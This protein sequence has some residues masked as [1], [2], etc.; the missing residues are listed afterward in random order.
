MIAKPK[1]YDEININEEFEKLELGGHKGIIIK[2]EEYTSDF[3][4]KKSLKV[5]VDTASDDKQPE[6]FK[7]QYENDTRIDRK[8]PNGA[9]KYV[10]LG[11]E[12]NQVKMLKS[13]ITAYENSNGCKF[14]WNKDWV[15]LKGKKIGLVFGM[16]EYLNQE[17]KLKTVNKLR[18]FRSIDK[19]DNVKIPKVKKLDNSYVDYEEY[20]NSKNS[21][22]E[23]FSDFGNI[24]EVSAEDLPF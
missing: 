24:V 9:I 17:G 3:S 11:E 10:P 14:D 4:G 12:E 5:Y 16:E 8:Y 1:T 21:S 2:A 15:Q 22:N 18:E 20:I 6:Y 7:K 19:V 13:F 23:P